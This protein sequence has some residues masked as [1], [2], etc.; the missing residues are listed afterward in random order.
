MA[1]AQQNERKSTRF[2]G[3]YQ[4]P[5]R[6][7]R[8]EG[9]PDVT[10]TIDYYDPHTGKRV[11]KAIGNRSDGITAE[12]ANSVRQTLMST[13]K[14]EVLEGIMPQT[15]KSVPTFGQAWLRY[16]T[17]WLEANEK[18]STYNDTSCYET[19]LKPRDIDSRSLNAITVVDLEKI[20]QE[21][22]AAGYAPQTIKTI[23][24]IV[25]RV[26]NKS[27]KWKMWR[28]PS[29]FNEFTMPE[30]D[31]ERTRYL[32][33]EDLEKVFTQ[34]KE[35]NHRA[36][37]MAVI[38]LQ[39]GL[40]FKD[41]AQ[42]EISDINFEDGTLFIRKPKNR[43]SR[44]VVMTQTVREALQEWLQAT[45]S[46]LVFPS[47]ANKVLWNVDEDF[48][49]VINGLGLN[50]NV[51]DNKD[52][53]VFHSLRHTYASHLAKQGYSEM[54]LAKLLGHRSTEMTRRYAHLMPGTQ[55][56]AAEELEMLFKVAHQASP[57]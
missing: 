36:W 2:D 7:K 33:E 14:K 39:C 4:R 42:L 8:Y 44:Y 18:A 45:R 29:P 50:D 10:Y 56:A 16:K 23:L 31:N 20:V 53:L 40:R 43:R 37:I 24:G 28:G 54:T 27:M 13:A 35:K 25:R 55:Q 34:L 51:T 57:Q 9:K 48:R 12:Y 49:E 22:R 6:T 38:A 3:V 11:R 15:G 21:K 1:A 52:K 41:I 32:S 5:S 26:M 47:K 17:D 46:H 19:H 30:V